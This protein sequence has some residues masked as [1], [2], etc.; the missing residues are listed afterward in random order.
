M[1]LIYH[2]FKDTGIWIIELH[3]KKM[4]LLQGGASSTKYNRLK[5]TSL[6][7]GK[8]RNSSFMVYLQSGTRI[9][10]DDTKSCQNVTQ[11]A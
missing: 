3:I 11:K 8:L 1:V 4:S 6:E 5:E 9:L 2:L 7:E 10:T